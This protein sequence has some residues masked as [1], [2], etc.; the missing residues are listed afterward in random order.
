MTDNKAMSLRQ[1]LSDIQVKLNAPKSQYNSFGKYNYRNAEDILS[2]VKP[3]LREHSLSLTLTD[4]IVQVGDR[5]YIKAEAKISDG[6]YDVFTTAFAREPLS[7]KGMDDSQVTGTASSYARKYAMNGLFAIDDV[8]DADN[9]DNRNNSQATSPRNEGSMGEAPMNRQ[10]VVKA[11]QETA[12]N[13]F[14]ATQGGRAYKDMLA[15]FGAK[16]TND[17]KDSDLAEALQYIKDYKEG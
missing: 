9:F 8:K 13:M 5:F 6:E 11:I 17:L 12:V 16:T 15:H 14:G 3:F 4:D 7:K 1:K 10:T 2:A